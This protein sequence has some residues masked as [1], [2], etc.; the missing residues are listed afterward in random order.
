MGLFFV[1]IL[2]SVMSE[3]RTNLPVCNLSVAKFDPRLQPQ[4]FRSKVLALGLPRSLIA[5][6]SYTTRYYSHNHLTAPV[7]SFRVSDS[8][9]NRGLHFKNLF[10]NRVA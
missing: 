9:A 8:R 3:I 2:K 1:E 7:T 4:L 6:P 10:M 5:L